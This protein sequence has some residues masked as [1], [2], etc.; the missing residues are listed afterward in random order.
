MSPGRSFLS[1]R[2]VQEGKDHALDNREKKGKRKLLSEMSYE[3]HA[4][5]SDINLNSAKK[6]NFLYLFFDIYDGL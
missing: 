3:E 5:S 6:S 2:P 4:L 1:T